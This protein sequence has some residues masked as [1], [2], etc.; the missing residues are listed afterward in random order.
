MFDKRVLYTIVLKSIFV[1]V[2]QKALSLDPGTVATIAQGVN[3]AASLFEKDAR[4]PE[5]ALAS[6]NR[7]LLVA[8]NHRLDHI[9]K[10]IA[11]ILNEVI[12][13][14]EKVFQQALRAEDVAVGSEISANGAV[15]LER[16]IDIVEAEAEADLS[17]RSWKKTEEYWEADVQEMSRDLARLYKRFDGNDIYPHTKALTHSTAAYFELAMRI[18]QMQRFGLA[19]STVVR[20]ASRHV[21]NLDSI[22]NPKIEG[23]LGNTVLSME[24]N[25][26]SDLDRLGWGD[27][28]SLMSGA[29]FQPELVGK[30]VTIESIRVMDPQ[31]KYARNWTHGGPWREYYWKQSKFQ[32][33][34]ANKIHEIEVHRSTDVIKYFTYDFTLQMK[35]ALNVYES[36]CDKVKDIPDPS[37]LD[38]YNKHQAKLLYDQYI[39]PIPAKIEQFERDYNR[40]ILLRSVLDV[41]VKA[42]DKLTLVQEGQFDVL[43]LSQ[44]EQVD[45]LTFQDLE[46]MFSQDKLAEKAQKAEQW[47]EVQQQL[48]SEINDLIADQN[49][50]LAVI[51]EEAADAA[52]T[53][54][55][56]GLLRAGLNATA[57]YLRS[58]QRSRDLEQL[59]QKISVISA[60]ISTHPDRSPASE[61][62][63]GGLNT[64]VEN[65]AWFGGV[66]NAKQQV[67]RLNNASEMLALSI[68]EGETR[69]FYV[70]LKGNSFYLLVP[71]DSA[72]MW[73]GNGTRLGATRIIVG[74]KN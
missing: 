22:A 71:A 68:P 35:D 26:Q 17:S 57:M 54:K 37:G 42:R 23:S 2:P 55:M 59:S 30:C 19:Q 31:P 74:K 52:K 44:M 34:M 13:L 56:I 60:E 1:A 15:F 62:I 10:G 27:K 3:M 70:V 47:E 66:H 45:T 46:K 6:D 4:D 29:A 63:V 20:A 67:E 33:L 25:L 7:E 65:I 16:Y 43:G 69:A 11:I 73:N 21:K 64:I 28:V 41:V 51:F 12:G 18:E 39:Y 36:V 48:R 32:V 53:N 24:Q 5:L 61:K 40:Y 49:S 9:E 14:E 72:Q 58:E 38:M 8:L 50:E